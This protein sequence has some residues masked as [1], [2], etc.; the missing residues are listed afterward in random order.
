MAPPPA[1]YM[2]DPGDYVHGAATAGAPGGS[3]ARGEGARHGP[4]TA[5][6]S[7]GWLASIK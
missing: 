6:S 5:N 3:A 1:M 4:Y 2:G 7:W